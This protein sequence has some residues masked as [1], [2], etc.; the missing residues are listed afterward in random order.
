[1]A[2]LRSTARAAT[3][4]GGATVLVL[5]GVLADT[6]AASPSTWYV[7]AAT[8]TD[9]S[10]CGAS[11]ATACATIGQAVTNAAAG[12]TV[13]VAAGSY[14]EQVTVG[15]RLTIS[16]PGIGNGPASTDATVSPPATDA[17]GFLI[18]SAAAGSTI[19]GFAVTGAQGEGILAMKTSNVTISD[20]LVM[21]NDLGATDPATTYA[22]CKAEGAAP[23]DCG[24]G[25]HL[26]STTHSRVENNIVEQNSGGILLTDE[27]GPT[28]HNVVAHN[29]VF[30]NAADC[31]ITLA[32]HSPAAAPGGKPNPS[33]AGIYDNLILGNISNNNGLLGF[34][35][36]VVLAGAG[37]GTAVYR[38]VVRG[39]SI[40]HNGLG[41]VTLHDHAPGQ[42]LMRNVIEDNVFDGNDTAGAPGPSAG[43]SNTFGATGG[44]L[45]QSAN[46]IVF[47]Q[48]DVE[49][50][51][52]I[53]G[54]TF[55]NAHFGIWTYNAPAIVRDNTFQ[56]SI[57][58]PVSQTPSP[59]RTRIN[60]PAR[61]KPGRTIRLH[62]TAQAGQRVT[63]YGKVRGS[64]HHRVGR[65]TATAT[66][67]WQLRLRTRRLPETFWA[68]AYY[69]RS[70]V[71]VVR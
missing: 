13:S 25:V 11:A 7:A 15:K 33:A 23:G 69:D 70:N 8:G 58:V 64:A 10:T 22:E 63:V 20:N 9:S 38:N 71:I 1:M 40:F 61:S 6:A 68:V 47:S 37:P 57:A 3:V 44:G 56:A 39:N 62:G 28:A 17:N 26:M 52:I 59:T 45:H 67:T 27:M 18:T 5:A 4:L 49:T 55:A 29:A 43:D 24:E 12:D 19:R 34:G 21:G 48:I 51:T 35:A 53:R 16:G 14:A 46:V 42:Y 60:G 2:M 54:N 30:D 32:G 65:V 41:G 66:G 31:G 36:G 50:G